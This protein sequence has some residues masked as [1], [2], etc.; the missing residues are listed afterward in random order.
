MIRLSLFALFACVLSSLTA[1]SAARAYD[2]AA[3]KLIGELPS[4]LDEISGLSVDPSHRNELLAIQDEEGKI[5][6]I[7]SKTGALLWAITF[8]KDGDYEAVEAVGEDIWVAKSTG[9][10]YHITNAG[11]P[12]QQVE[13]YNTDLTSE[14]DVEGL[15]YDKLKNRLLLACSSPNAVTTTVPRR[16]SWANTCPYH[17]PPLSAPSVM[18][19]NLRGRDRT[20]VQGSPPME[21]TPPPTMLPSP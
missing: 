16:L 9:T 12:N 8:W 6:R 18:T 4:E 10:L 1:Q 15:A 3:P 2:Y 19:C 14:N 5:F 21:P 13:K 17:P 20:W 7:N 11:K